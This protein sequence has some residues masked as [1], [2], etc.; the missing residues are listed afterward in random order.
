MA[1]ADTHR[2]GAIIPAEYQFVLA[3]AGPTTHMGLTIPSINVDKVVELRRSG[4][5]FALTG[6][7]FN[8]SVCGAAFKEG[9]IWRHEPSGEHIYVGHQCAVK[10]Q[11]LADLSAF[12][13]EQGRVRD[14][15]AR[16]FQRKI[17]AEQRAAFLAA[18]PGLEAALETKHIIVEDIAEKFRNRYTSLTPAQ[19]ALVFKLANEAASPKTVE[20][21]IPA[22]EG[23]A[24]FRGTIVS[25]KTVEDR[26]NRYGR[27]VITVKVSTPEGIWLAWGTAPLIRRDGPRL[28]ATDGIV[29]IDKGDEIEITATL[30]RG[31]EPHFAFFK[32][33]R[34][35]LVT[36]KVEVAA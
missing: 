32:R 26:W 6:S 22:P 25:I 13:L 20:I 15:A 30:T 33:P 35:K 1:R 31:R 21:N 3:Y 2:P 28:H 9:Q 14:A 23:R 5:K 29:P 11:L 4:A 12:E 18:N 16:E 27:T 8:C 36:P 10:Y 24:T 17:N 34:A 7:T 19:V